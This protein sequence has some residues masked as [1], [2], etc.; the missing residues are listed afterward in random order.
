MIECI[1]E[2]GIPL[3]LCVP[4]S[5]IVGTPPFKSRPA[6]SLTDEKERDLQSA[7]LKAQDLQYSDEV[8]LAAAKECLLLD[9]FHAGANYLCGKILFDRGLTELP[10]RISSEHETTMYAQEQQAQIPQS[11]AMQ[12]T[13]FVYLV[14]VPKHLDKKIKKG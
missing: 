14:D 11:N 9:Q 5:D 6:P 2:S 10:N 8:R 7:W 3:L 12:I 4:V 1:S 13:N